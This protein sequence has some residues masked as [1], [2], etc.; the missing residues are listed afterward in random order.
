MQRGFDGMSPES[1]R[2]RFPASAPFLQPDMAARAADVDH[3]DHGCWV[4]G[5]SGE[6]VGIGRYLR[7][8]DESG[9]AEVA[10]EVVDACQGQ[11][12]GR[13]LLDAVQIA[14]CAGAAR[15]RAAERTA[16]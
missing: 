14:R 6:P 16:A 2:M 10:L 11:G 9:V 15:R 13:L 8:D 7:T 12:V 3:V 1:R 4:T 5:I